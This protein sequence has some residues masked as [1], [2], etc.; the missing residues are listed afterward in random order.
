M[1]HIVLYYFGQS[2]I[3][4][5]HMDKQGTHPI[6]FSQLHQLRGRIGRDGSK[7][8]CILVSDDEEKDKLEDKKILFDKKQNLQ[9]I[10]DYINPLINKELLITLYLLVFVFTK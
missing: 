5:G 3:P 9:S 4:Q 10:C 8:T 1:G 2:N 7:A 6:L